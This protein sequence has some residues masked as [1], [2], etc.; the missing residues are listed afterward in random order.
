MFG[1]NEL[2]MRCGAEGGGEV[3]QSFWWSLNTKLHR[4]WMTFYLKRNNNFVSMG[5]ILKMII[6]LWHHYQICNFYPYHAFHNSIISDQQQGR[7]KE[8]GAKHHQDIR[9]DRDA[10][11]RGQVQWWREVRAH[12]DTEKVAHRCHDPSQLL[13]GNLVL[14]C[15]QACQSSESP[16]IKSRST[17]FLWCWIVE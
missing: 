5:H 11:A 7:I 17:S 10:A 16:K 8:D 6:Q 13:S 14:F 4:F 1:G 15:F 12:P 3:A 9:Q 2:Y